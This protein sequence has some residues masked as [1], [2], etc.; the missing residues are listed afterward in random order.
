MLQDSYGVVKKTY[1]DNGFMHSVCMR[2]DVH[3]R[4][5]VRMFSC[6]IESNPPMRLEQDSGWHGTFA[7]A[8]FAGK[9]W[10]IVHLHW[11]GDTSRLKRQIFEWD[12]SAQF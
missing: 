7:V 9:R 11:A 2:E 3:G 8:S 5:A 10:F 12:N 6:R 1:V 4:R